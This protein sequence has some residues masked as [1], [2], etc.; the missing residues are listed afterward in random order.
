MQQQQQRPMQKHTL[1]HA[2]IKAKVM[3]IPAYTTRLS[4]AASG[5]EVGAGELASNAKS[6]TLQDSKQDSSPIQ[7]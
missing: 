5:E 6:C 1:K 4:T 2:V 3:P 7:A